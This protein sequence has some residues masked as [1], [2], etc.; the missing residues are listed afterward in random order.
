MP[1]FLA[2]TAYPFTDANAENS[3][4]GAKKYVHL[5]VQQRNGRKSL[6]N[7][8]VLKKDF[9]YSTIIK[10]LKKEFCCNATGSRIGPGVHVVIRGRT[11]QLSLFRLALQARN[12]ERFVVFEQQ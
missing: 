4:A 9:S 8:Q 5:S 11:C 2:L 1:K 7:V 6:A 10:E 12:T 3:G